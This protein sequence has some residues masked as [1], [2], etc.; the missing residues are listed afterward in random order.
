MDKN[1][2]YTKDAKERLMLCYSCPKFNKIARVC[3]ICHCFMLIKIHFE[4]AKCPDE[5]RRW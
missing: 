5:P 4:N 2:S 3:T 1:L